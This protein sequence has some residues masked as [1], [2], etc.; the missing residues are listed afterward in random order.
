MYGSEYFDETSEKN[1]AVF[2][3]YLEFIAQCGIRLEG[4][5]VLDIG[6]GTGALLSVLHARGIRAYGTDISP[7]AVARA[8]ERFGGDIKVAVSNLEHELPPFDEKF[9]AIFMFDVIEH[10]RCF[11][12]FCKLVELRLAPG[13]CICI[14]T[15][16]ANSLLRF[17]NHLSFTGELDSTHTMLF[18]PYTLDFF[19]RRARLEQKVIATPY[20]FHFRLNLFTRIVPFGG[21]I[22]A[23]YLRPND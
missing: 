14:T 16:N 10:M 20:A 2:E 18:T 1:V 8:N 9:D 11:E 12:V 13:G 7:Y 3:R 21:Q 22:F 17:G 6:C 23:I 15:P 4:R 19:L 5:R